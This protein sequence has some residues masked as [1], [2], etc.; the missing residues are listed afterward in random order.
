[1]PSLVR[2]NSSFDGEPLQRLSSIRELVN[3]RLRDAA[4]TTRNDPAAV[5]SC[6]WR[7]RL[8]PQIALA[9]T[10]TADASSAVSGV[11][12]ARHMPPNRRRQ[13]RQDTARP[14]A[15]PRWALPWQRPVI[16]RTAIR[17]ACS[18]QRARST[19]QVASHSTYSSPQNTGD[20]LQSSE[21][22][23]ASSASSPCSA[24]PRD[25]RRRCDC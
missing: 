14:R 19:R 16:P 12:R 15:H 2:C 8:S 3:Y 20:K 22:H 25:L 24:A 17:V 1:V 7:T 9:S 5:R 6:T 21:V 11:H 10:R 4:T 18:T 13:Q 23:Q